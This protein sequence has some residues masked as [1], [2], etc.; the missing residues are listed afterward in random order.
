MQINNKFVKK[1]QK[2]PQNLHKTFK[3]NQNEQVLCKV[4]KFFWIYEKIKLIIFY[5]N[6]CAFNTLQKERC[7]SR[8]YTKI[9]L[10]IIKQCFEKRKNKFHDSYKIF[11]IF[12]SS[13]FSTIFS[14]RETITTY[15]NVQNYI[16]KLFYITVGYFNVHS[17]I[18]NNKMSD[19]NQQQFKGRC[20]EGESVT[21]KMDF[22]SIF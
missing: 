21:E 15:N 8:K 17:T 18:Y 3:G 14:T 10:Q 13:F 16:V 22:F 6:F 20:F 9:Y 5:T 2:S 4:T 1:L 11:G 7:I 19:K 12:K